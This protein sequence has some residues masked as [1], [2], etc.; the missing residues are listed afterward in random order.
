MSL[1]HEKGVHILRSLYRELRPSVREPNRHVYQTP[2]WKYIVKS[3]R[4]IPTSNHFGDPS[5][6]LYRV[7]EYYY[8]AIKGTREYLRLH[9]AYR[10]KGERTPTDLAEILG[11]RMPD[12]PTP[13]PRRRKLDNAKDPNQSCN[14]SS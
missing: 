9:E 11:F 4:E 5:T 12:D 1:G 3:C 6:I 14:K 2:A 13:D 7:G 10:G 8:N